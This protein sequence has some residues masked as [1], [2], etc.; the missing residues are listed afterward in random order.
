MHSADKEGSVKMGDSKRYMAVKE[1]RLCYYQNEDVSY[2]T[3]SCRTFPTGARTF[4]GHP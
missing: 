3:G 2:K 4:A 1:G